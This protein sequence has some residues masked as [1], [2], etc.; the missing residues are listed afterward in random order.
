MVSPPDTKLDLEALQTG[1]DPIQV[2]E[3]RRW[4]AAFWTQYFG[5]KIDWINEG[6]RGEV[7]HIAIISVEIFPPL[8]LRLPPLQ[9]HLD[10]ESTELVN[11]AAGCRFDLVGQQIFGTRGV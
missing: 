5:G 6:I 1:Y 2:V 3:F 10:I 8:F 7:N 9:L 4:H 11:R